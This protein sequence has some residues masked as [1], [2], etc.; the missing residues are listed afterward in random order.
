VILSG[1]GFMAPQVLGSGHGAVQFH[2][3]H[4]LDASRAGV[5]L[6]LKLIA[7]AVSVAR[8]S[9]R[10]VLVVALHR[11]LAPVRVF[12]QSR[13]LFSPALAKAPSITSSCWPAWARSP[14]ASSAR[15]L[16]MVF[17]VLEATGDFQVAIAVVIAVTISSTI[18][19]SCSAI[20]F[21]T[22]AIPCCAGSR[23]A[24]PMTWA[25]SATMNV[26]R[27][28]RSDAKTVPENLGLKALRAAYPA[29]STKRLYVVG[30]RGRSLLSAPST[31]PNC[32]MPKSNDALDGAVGGPTWRKSPSNSAASEN[33]RSALANLTPAGRDLAGADTSAQ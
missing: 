24:V 21:A 30:L 26:G 5:L 6:A 13:G 20:A 25:G 9:R 16:T 15:P 29:G 10:A 14:P 2:F 3:R 4:T 32:T 23:S 33:I 12:A 11:R 22:L 27:F 28:M 8:V 31:P 7:S 18:V 17:L 19:A 1:L